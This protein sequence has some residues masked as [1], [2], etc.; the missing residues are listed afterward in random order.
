[1]DCIVVKSFHKKPVSKIEEQK[2]SISTGFPRD[3]ECVILYDD[4]PH[5]KKPENTESMI[6]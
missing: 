1:M 4:K 2:N 5:S 3:R 6:I